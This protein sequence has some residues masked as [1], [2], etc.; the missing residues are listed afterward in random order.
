[1][2]I[3]IQLG[4]LHLFED[5]H[6]LTPLLAINFLFSNNLLQLTMITCGKF[7]PLFQLVILNLELLQ[8]VLFA[9]F[10][11]SMFIYQRFVS[12]HNLLFS[13]AKHVLLSI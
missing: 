6:L 3:R 13:L 11:F 7:K 4:T 2:P 10:L 8:N 9:R 1:M 12:H 5:L